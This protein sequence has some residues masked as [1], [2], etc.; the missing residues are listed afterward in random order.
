MAWV[1]L[2]V[3]KLRVHSVVPSHPHSFYLFSVSS[4]DFHFT[5]LKVSHFSRGSENGQPSSQVEDTAI[6]RRLL[7]TESSG[8]CGSNL[9]SIGS[10]RLGE[11]STVGKD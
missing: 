6:K 4:L 8:S 5:G 9:S 11:T 7:G 1:N 3:S 10:Y 2:V